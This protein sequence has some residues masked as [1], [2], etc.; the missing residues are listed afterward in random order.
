MHLIAIKSVS[1]RTRKMILILP[2]DF[3]A[4]ICRT[5]FCQNRR[6]NFTNDNCIW[7]FA[8]HV[9]DLN[10]NVKNNKCFLNYVDWKPNSNFSGIFIEF[11]FDFDWTSNFFFICIGSV[12]FFGCSRSKLRRKCF[13]SS[14]L[15]SSNRQSFWQFSSKIL[16]CRLFPMTRKSVQLRDFQLECLL[17]NLFRNYFV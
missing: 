14:P 3:E 16:L 7:K 17:I 5:A 2:T 10:S 4:H 9:R 8:D 13:A 1:P 15:F 11:Y 6:V 12:I